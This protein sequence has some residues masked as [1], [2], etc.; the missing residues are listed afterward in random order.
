MKKLSRE[1]EIKLRLANVAVARRSLRRLGFRAVQGRH[2]ERNLLFDAPRNELQ[3]TKRMLRLRTAGRRAWLTFKGPASG[4][5]RFKVRRE[6]ETELSKPERARAILEALGF[7]VVF[8]YEKYRTVFAAKGALKQGEVMLDETPIG[9]FLELEGSAHWIRRV[10]KSLGRQAGEFIAADYGA[11]Y[12]AWCRRA[13][14]R[15]GD[16]VFRLRKG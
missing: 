1:T 9:D 6:V 15:P 10:A 8:R 4:D 7:R 3:R 14:R 13:G 12:R 11:L 16:M 2:L 5:S